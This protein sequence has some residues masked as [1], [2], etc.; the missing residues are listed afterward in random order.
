GGGSIEDLWAFN[1][2]IVARAIHDCRLPIVSGVGHE[3]DFTIADFVADARA[4]TPTAAA[5][6]ATPDRDH[7][8]KAIAH[9]YH[10]LARML[11]RRMQHMDMLA[12]RLVHPGERIASQL[13]EL[14]HL[15]GR[16]A[17]AWLHTGDDMTWRLRELAQDLKAAR[18]DFDALRIEQHTLARRL[19][20]SL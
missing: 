8:C 6:M 17:R 19:R 13:Q 15:R 16:L 18:P 7:L 10:R 14:C 3:T 12:R 11:E 5:Q 1:E 20:S 2:E 9:L 4:P